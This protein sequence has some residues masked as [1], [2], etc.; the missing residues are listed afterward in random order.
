MCI[1]TWDCAGHMVSAVSMFFVANVT[2]I[3]SALSLGYCAKGVS[4]MLYQTPL[5]CCSHTLDT[6]FPPAIDE[7]ISHRSTCQRL[8]QDPAWHS[9]WATWISDTVNSP[10]DNSG[11]VEH[12]CQFHHWDS[13]ARFSGHLRGSQWDRAQV[14]PSSGFEEQTLPH[15][16][17]LLCFT[18]VR[19]KLLLVCRRVTKEVMSRHH[20]PK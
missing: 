10:G 6:H 15:L 8:S 14:P 9:R 12:R 2:S 16:S 3:Y 19:P 4:N 13:Q 17:L 1:K 11:P 7:A 5:I 18:I 20:F